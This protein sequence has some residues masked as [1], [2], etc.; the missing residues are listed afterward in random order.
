MVQ[1]VLQAGILSHSTRA[2]PMRWGH[3]YSA[4]SATVLQGVLQAGIVS[5]AIGAPPV[6][7]ANATGASVMS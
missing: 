5:H 1:G 7:R 2:A 3:R 6:L 4:T